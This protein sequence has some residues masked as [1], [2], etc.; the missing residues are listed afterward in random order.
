MV[1]VVHLKYIMY[2]II[3]NLHI[4]NFYKYIKILNNIFSLKS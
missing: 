1:N 2:L 3:N 4:N